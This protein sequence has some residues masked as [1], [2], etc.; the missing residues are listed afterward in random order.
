[1]LYCL[2]LEHA[3]AN[4]LRHFHLNEAPGSVV[5][6]LYFVRDFQARKETSTVLVE[7]SGKN[8]KPL[9]DYSPYRDEF[10]KRLIRLFEEIYDPNIP[11]RQCKDTKPCEWCPFINLCKRI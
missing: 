4:D 10:Q 2:L 5:P 11:F 6:H 3:S 7:G 9:D 8:A 1:M